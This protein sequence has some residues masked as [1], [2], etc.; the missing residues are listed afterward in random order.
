LYKKLLHKCEFGQAHCV[1]L[2]KRSPTKFSLPFLN[3]PTI[4]NE[5]CKFEIISKIYLNKKKKKRLKQC[6]GRIL[7]AHLRMGPGAAHGHTGPHLA[8]PFRA[9]LAAH[10]ENRGGRPP[11]LRGGSAGGRSSERRRGAVGKRAAEHPNRVGKRVEELE[12][13]EAHRRT[14]T[15]VAG[16][17]RGSSTVRVSTGGFLCGSTSRQ[18]VRGRGGAGGGYVGPGGRTDKAGHGEALQA[19]GEVDG[20]LQLR[21]T[22][23]RVTEAT[24]RSAVAREW[25]RGTTARGGGAQLWGLEQLARSRKE[26]GG[27]RDTATRRDG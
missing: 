25:L 1:D 9:G 3:I 7:R 23:A 18:G 11:W 16:V 21:L 14:S 26:S 20:G 13:G 6:M 22:R 2:P 8:G 27:D 19:V 4:F 10:A 17:G 15:M 12:Q 5:F 24:K